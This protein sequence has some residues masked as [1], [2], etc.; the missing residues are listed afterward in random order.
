MF[1][2]YIMY[3]DVAQVVDMQMMLQGLELCFCK[4]RSSFEKLSF[5]TPDKSTDR[6]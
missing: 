2:D 4:S 6:T 3:Q 1:M 5:P